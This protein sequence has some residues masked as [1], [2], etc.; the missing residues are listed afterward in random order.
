[1]QNRN[2][3]TDILKKKN[4]WLPR[5]KGLGEWQISGIGWT[6]INYYKQK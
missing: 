2:R 6:D 3:L 1:M 5:E 4:L